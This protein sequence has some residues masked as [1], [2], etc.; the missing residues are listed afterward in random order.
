M[1]LSPEAR[2]EHERLE[3]MEVGQD[4]VG[5]VERRDAS[6][7]RLGR[8]RGRRCPGSTPRPCPIRHAV[9]QLPPGWPH[10]SCRC[11]RPRS[12]LHEPT[13]GRR[14]P[15]RG[16]Q[17]AMSDASTRC[18]EVVPASKPMSAT[19][20][21]PTRSGPSLRTLPRRGR[22]E[23]HR[24]ARRA[25]S[26]TRPHRWPHPGRSAHRPPGSGCCRCPASAMSR[27][28]RCRMRRR[29]RGRRSGETSGQ[30][31]ASKTRTLTPRSR[32]R[33]PATRPSAPLLPGPATMLT[34][35]PYPP[36][37]RRS[38]ECATAH[39]AR[40]I[41]TSTGVSARASTSRIC[42]G[43][44]TGIIESSFCDDVGDGH[45]IG[46]RQAHVPPGHP[47][48]VRQLGRPAGECER[49]GSGL[50]TLDPHV[51]KAE[52]TEPETQRLHRP[53]RGLRTGPPATA[54]DRTAVPRR[55]A[56]PR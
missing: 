18:V 52:R 5:P 2:A 25:A 23:R 29:R 10:R 36:P 47:R 56:R 54:P 42:S 11:C 33:F 22:T 4:R 45:Q 21:S 49:R 46:M 30:S 35:R 34:I 55:R 7:D 43:V 16:T 20:S 19:V 15:R 38:A 12:E 14:R 37:R 51:V 17:A 44:R 48:F 6:F 40:S 9:R 32:N 50:G 27:G 24:G 8:D 26:T 39:P 28:S 3:A 53:L 1:L 41:S 31:S 13:C